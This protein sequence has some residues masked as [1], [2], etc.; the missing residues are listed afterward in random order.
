MIEKVGRSTKINSNKHGS[1]LHHS[2][3]P[4]ERI[5]G[6]PGS[7]RFLFLLVARKFTLVKGREQGEGGQQIEVPDCRVPG[8]KIPREKIQFTQNADREKGEKGFKVSVQNSR[9]ILLLRIHFQGLERSNIPVG[10]STIKFIK[11]TL[12]LI[13]VCDVVGLDISQKPSD[14]LLALLCG[15]WAADGGDCAILFKSSQKIDNQFKSWPSLHLNSHDSWTTHS[16]G[17][18]SVTEYLID[19]FQTIFNQFLF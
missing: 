6:A 16:S 8:V 14:M 5:L 7:K 13:N 12:H 2:S 15:F 1:L 9:L 4:K 17:L 11:H 18:D 19:F 3:L 10:M